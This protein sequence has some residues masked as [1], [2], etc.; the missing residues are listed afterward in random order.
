VRA[1][2]EVTP[3]DRRLHRTGKEETAAGGTVQP[4]T[5]GI[6]QLLLL[7]Q[8]GD[9]AAAARLV[10]VL[11]PGFVRYC[12]S[13]GDS[14]QDVDD[15]LQDIWLRIHRARHTYR[16]GTPAAPW[17]YAIARHTRLDA[18]R[19]RQRFRVRELQADALPELP[20]LVP[21][22]GAANMTEILDCLPAGQ[23]EVLVMLKGCGMTLEE[24]ARVTSSTIGAVKQKAH[25]AYTQLRALIAQTQQRRKL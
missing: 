7:Y 25:R 23:R 16:P 4:R 11:S 15:I 21:E 12:L 6:E 18:R 13:Q 14:A 3:H 9:T 20:A 5:T 2:S 8:Q 19:R 1:V 24:V 22:P 17:L 10:R